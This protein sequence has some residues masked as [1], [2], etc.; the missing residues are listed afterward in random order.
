MAAVLYCFTKSMTHSAVDHRGKRCQG[1]KDFK[2]YCLSDFV[3]W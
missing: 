1:Y 3:V 2:V